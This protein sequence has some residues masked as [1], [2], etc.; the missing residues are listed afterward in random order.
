MSLENIWNPWHGCRKVSEGCENCYMYYLDKT[1]DRDGSVIHKTKTG[2]RVPVSKNR[3]GEYKIKSGELVNVCLTSDFFL[4]E[5]DDWR[6]DAW[7]MIRQ[8]PDVK[9]FLLTKRPERI[10]DCLPADWGDGWENVMVSV[11]CENQKRADERISILLELPI[12]HKGIICAPLLDEISIDKY[13]LSGQIEEVFCGGENYE[14]A[15]PCNYDWVLKLRNE[16]V[17]N[18]VTFSWFGTG[19]VFIKGNKKYFLP[20]KNVQQKMV[21]KSGI[22]FIGKEFVWKLYSEDGKLLTKEDLYKPV[23]RDRCSMC[24]SRATCKGCTNCG[25]C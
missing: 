15:R 9:F 11:S 10:R 25:R 21:A 18:D 13:L 4:A 1:R 16:C 2:F 6:E 19:T 23:Y 20:D 22:N 3:E 14:G 17:K 7:N 5:A 8:R 24:G 12:K